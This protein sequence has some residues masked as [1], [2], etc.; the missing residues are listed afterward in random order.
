M[1]GCL[2]S[3]SQELYLHSAFGTWL[4]T[5]SIWS[6]PL[7]MI[8]EMPKGL[9]FRLPHFFGNVHVL[10]HFGNRFISCYRIYL[11]FLFH[12]TLKIFLGLISLT[13]WS[14]PNRNCWYMSLLLRGVSSY[15][16]GKKRTP[17]YAALYTRVREVELLEELNSRLHDTLE[18]HNK[19][20]ELW[21]PKK[22]TPWLHLFTYRWIQLLV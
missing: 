21:H 18:N 8:M 13:L 19:V 15:S 11:T 14:K 9:R 1:A 16:T 7:A 10:N 2:V 17:S 4:L 20:W 22:D 3:S 12:F 6:I 5:S